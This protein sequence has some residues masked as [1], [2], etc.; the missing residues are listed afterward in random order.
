M[1]K[2]FDVVATTGKYQKDGETKYVNK[3]VGAVI[4]TQHGLSLVL[5]ASFNPAGCP[6]SEDGKVWLRLFEPKDDNQKPAQQS[7]QNSN[8]TQASAAPSNFDN[9]DDDIPF[10]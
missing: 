3:N 2:Q 1:A 6:I 7:R 8:G 9:F 4:Q 10:N 5:D